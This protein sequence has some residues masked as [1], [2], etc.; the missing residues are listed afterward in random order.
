MSRRN[1]KS[2][3][4]FAYRLAP[5]FTVCAD[6]PA[7]LA[8]QH[9]WSWLEVSHGKLRRRYCCLAHGPEQAIDEALARLVS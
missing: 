6:C 4:A 9:A 2:L 1:A 7:V 5:A 3:I 8:G